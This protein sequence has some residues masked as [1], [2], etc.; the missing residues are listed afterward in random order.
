MTTKLELYKGTVT[1]GELK[2][3]LAEIPDDVEI[4]VWAGNGSGY[5]DGLEFEYTDWENPEVVNS[6]EIN[7]AAESAYV[8]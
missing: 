8:Y 6:L 5:I 2:S 4:D 7:V 3:F 1:V